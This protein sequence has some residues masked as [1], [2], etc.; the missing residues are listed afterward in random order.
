MTVH[1]QRRS[2]LR[3][4]LSEDVRCVFVTRDLASV[5]Y[6]TGFS[7]S[8]A[9]VVI[10]TDEAH[11]ITDGRYREQAHHESPDVAAVIDRDVV[12]ALRGL[13]AGRKIALD[14]RTP[15][16]MAQQLTKA[17]LAV[18]AVADPVAPLRMVKDT[19]ELDALS[20]AG[21]ISARALEQVADTIAVGDREADIARRLEAAFAEWGADDRAFATIV[22]S[23]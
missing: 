14:D 23:G 19:Q 21:G 2:R 12:G 9:A 5:R 15:V 22:A 17:G 20:R 11:L 1:H 4:A 10:G 16:G 3:E 7:G 18:R 13:S 8:N 6:L